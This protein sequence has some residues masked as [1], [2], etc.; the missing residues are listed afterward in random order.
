MVHGIFAFSVFEQAC[1][2]AH[3]AAAFRAKMVFHLWGVVEFVPVYFA[4]QYPERI[5]LNPLLA[6]FAKL[7]SL[8]AFRLKIFRQRFSESR[9]AILAAERVKPD[10]YL[11]DSG[12]VQDIPREQY[13]FSVG[14]GGSVP[15]IFHTQLVELGYLPAWGLSYLNIGP[16]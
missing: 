16:M 5:L 1:Y 10:I 14:F 12:P 8:F 3:V 7:F 9:P 15:E 13:H 2:P 11:L 4:V 6:V